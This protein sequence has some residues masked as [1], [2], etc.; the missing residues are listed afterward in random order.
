MAKTTGIIYNMDV[1]KL[2]H[3]LNCFI[4]AVSR[5]QSAGTPQATSADVARLSS[6]TAEIN[7]Y[8]QHTI[9]QP[10]LGL[11]ETNPR[12]LGFPSLSGIPEMEN[13]ALFMA[14]SLL[15]TARDEMIKLTSTRLSS[16][17]VVFDVTRLSAII[18]KCDAL[19]SGY[20]PTATT[21]DLSESS[22]R[23]AM[24]PDGL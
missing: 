16:N 15:E 12:T 7:T 22:P 10:V 3:L 11:P 14:A 6:Y 8:L 18:S 2:V 5:S 1:L 23:A 24:P 13:D 4:E 9:A 17:L 20:I 19:V 21:I